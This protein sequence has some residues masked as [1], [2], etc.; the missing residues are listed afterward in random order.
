MVAFHA[1]PKAMSLASVSEAT[2]TDPTMMKLI[3]MI[4]RGTWH[5]ATKTEEGVNNNFLKTC[6]KVKE[7]LATTAEGDIILR[8]NRILLPESLQ[9]KAIALAHAGHQGL[10]KTKQL[11]RTKLWFPGIDKLVE[12]QISL[13]IPCQAVTDQKTH[14]PLHMTELPGRPWEEIAADFKGPLKDGRYLLVV[15]DLYSRY[16]FVKLV[17]T[18]SA[19][20]VIPKLDELFAE[21]GNP[22]TLTTDNGPP[23]SSKDFKKFSESL[24]FRHRRITP[25]WPQA[26]GEAER[27][28]RTLNKVAQTAEIE[29]VPVL[30]AITEFL[31]S[32]RATPHST[33]GKTPSELLWKRNSRGRLPEYAQ[34]EQDDELRQRDA[35][36][37]AKM[38]QYADGR[39]TTQS[40]IA[41]GDIVLVKQTR[42]NKT[43]PIFNPKPYTVVKRKETMVTAER[44]GHTITRNISFFKRIPDRALMQDDH[45]QENDDEDD[46]DSI[47]TYGQG[48][49]DQNINNQ[50]NAN[51]QHEAADQPQPVDQPDHVHHSPGH[52][53]HQSPRGRP[54]RLRR[55]PNRFKDFVVDINYIS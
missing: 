45:D 52:A 5:E 50:P 51:G 24:G 22:R 7:E 49:Q 44:P 9:Q 29:N 43:T 26:N 11:L 42:L 46:D 14:E 18:T 2:L 53:Q 27:M 20:A 12:E 40:H 21:Q 33:T 28:M 39:R 8:G 23:F 13:C 15:I 36:R 31:R 55:L 17:T 37:K 30:R 47:V 54:V 35:E 1:T 16:P 10:V 19:A 4:Q 6:A 3:D 48:I 34:A 25:A 41:E 32:Y 38:K